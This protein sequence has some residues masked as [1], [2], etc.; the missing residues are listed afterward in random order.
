MLKDITRK[1]LKLAMELINYDDFAKVEFR[2]GEIKEA[3]AVE[4]SEKL[5]RLVVDFGKEL[6]ER[7]VFSGIKKWYQLEELI[8]KK[9]VFVINMV[10]KK[11][12]GEESQAMIFGAENGDDMSILLLD[13]DLDNG[14]KVF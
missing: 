7:I 10:P 6:G 3:Q 8:N 9:T 1:M 2:I 12:M 4:G 14:S 5:I 11:I 13:K